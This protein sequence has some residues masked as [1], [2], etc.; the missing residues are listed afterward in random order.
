M[1]VGITQVVSL[2]N[3]AIC[4]HTNVWPVLNV[5]DR[6]ITLF[7]IDKYMFLKRSSLKISNNILVNYLNESDKNQKPDSQMDA[8]SSMTC[9]DDY[10]MVRFSFLSK[11]F[12]ITISFD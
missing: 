8:S 1:V 2:T 4:S 7:R 3:L 5:K 11:L 6:P 9:S 12:F 10:E